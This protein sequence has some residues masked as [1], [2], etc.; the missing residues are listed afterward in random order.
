M[1]ALTTAK[2]ILILCH[3][4]A[5]PDTLGAAYALSQLL[6]LKLPSAEV[7]T[8]APEGVSRLG[9][10]VLRRLPLSIKSSL[11]LDRADTFLLVDTNTLAQLGETGTYVRSSGRPLVLVDHHA[12]H[13]ET[14]KLA[15]LSLADES[16]SSTCE[17]VYMLFQEAGVK[18]DVNTALALFLGIA[19]D[20]RHF[21]LAKYE[22]FR[23]ISRLIDAGL[24]V[25]EALPLLAQTL[26][27]SERTARLKA[28]RRLERTEIRG[29][30]IVN[31][32]VG[33]YQSSAAR[34]LL[35]LG[36]DVAAVGGEKK[37]KIRISLRA[38][39]S[40]YERTRVHMGQD[41]A[42]PL[43][44]AIGGMGGGHSTAAGVNGQGTLD[45]ALKACQTI[46][47]AAISVPQEEGPRTR[48][49]I[50]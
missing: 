48:A 7:E 44:R 30:M 15:L 6:T 42:A 50:H 27:L 43:G 46:L 2:S 23:I 1:E 40:F 12:P 28:A 8:A 45:N 29:W 18:P 33:S 36:A 26:D 35:A 31:S 9:K 14:Q 3:Q 21:I 20:T 37:G 19:Y 5:D 4:N 10:Q 25:E 11:G 39:K 47:G 16:A 22:T 49:T 17:I 24:V 41:I 34:G 13:S 38:T 32:R